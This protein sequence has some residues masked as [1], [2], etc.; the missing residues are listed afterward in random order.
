LAKLTPYL[1]VPVALPSVAGTT[2]SQGG[3]LGFCQS[4]RRLLSQTIAI[5]RHEWSKKRLDFK[6]RATILNYIQL[7]EFFKPGL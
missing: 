5:K 6:Q 2:I 4:K 7:K 1:P 3:L